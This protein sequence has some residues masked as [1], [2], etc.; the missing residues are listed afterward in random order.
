ME[1]LKG[2][3]HR[4]GK[5]VSPSPDGTQHTGVSS[6]QGDTLNTVDFIGATVINLVLQSAFQGYPITSENYHPLS[7]LILGKAGIG[8]SRLLMTMHSLRK[9]YLD[10]ISYTDDI[11]PKFLVDFLHRVERGEKRFL[12]IPDFQVITHS[13]GRKT[14]G[15]TISILR[16]M[17]SDGISN[18]DS[19]G[20]DFHPEFKVRAGLITATTLRSY[21]DFSEKWK[22]DGFLSRLIPYSFIHSAETIDTTL[23][24]I[25]YHQ[26]TSLGITYHINRNPQR[27]ADNP[28]ITLQLRGYA[29]PLS[30]KTEA[31]PYRAMNQLISLTKMLAIIKNDSEVTQEHIDLLI[32]LMRYIN[33]D[34][35]AI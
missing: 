13:H 24:Q 19:F 18:L 9:K 33:Y 16:Q 17:I 30:D 15:T 34:F 14:Y 3:F 20:M 4:N 21:S 25:A 23:K 10:F 7:L 5:S 6:S 27:I 26:D 31:L 32:R 35:N 11:T 29:E 8:K 12:V 28:N 2:I 22:K 1:S